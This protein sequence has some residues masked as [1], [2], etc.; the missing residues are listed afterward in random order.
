M[1]KSGRS[2]S[3]LGLLLQA[4][5][6]LVVG[7]CA[8]PGGFLASE[9]SSVF[10]GHDVL[11]PP[12]RAVDLRAQMR[13][14]D[15]LQGRPGLAVRFYR[16]GELY[17]VAETDAEGVATVAFTPPAE[18]NFTFAAEI[19]PAGITGDVPRPASLLVACRRPQTPIAI[20]DLD[21]TVVAS[22]FQD[23]LIGD[24]KPM[25]GSQRVLAELARTHSIVYLTYRP[26]VFGRESKRWLAAH[27]YPVGPLLLR[28]GGSM[29]SS[30]GKYKAAL[31][32]SLKRDF[33]R[34]EVGIG[35]KGSD[36]RAYHDNGL[37]AILVHS[38]PQSASP[39]ERR[40]EAKELESLPP[41]VNVVTNWSEVAGVLAGKGVDVRGQI[42]R[43]LR[44]GK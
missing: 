15:F 43:E 6:C 18:G 10:V 11:T 44:E 37:K 26:D 24:P 27:D 2:A 5:A 40:R 39:T 34:L 1:M 29:F 33:L 21:K 31:L 42:I 20:I 8:A 35:D 19:V 23:V 32:A 28:G 16:D 7:G 13:G 25:P 3:R 36:A 30:S 41:G 17:K 12:N 14:G 9:T 4:A 38:A 22:G